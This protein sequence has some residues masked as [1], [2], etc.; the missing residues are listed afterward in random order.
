VNFHTSL[1]SNH[2]Q[3]WGNR[4]L[5]SFAMTQGKGG[6]AGG[7]I[8]FHSPF[9]PSIGMKDEPDNLTHQNPVRAAGQELV[10]AN[11]NF[12]ALSKIP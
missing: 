8:D 10:E 1:P 3:G 11:G 4:P 7:I 2:H 5:I 6:V 9:D 12:S